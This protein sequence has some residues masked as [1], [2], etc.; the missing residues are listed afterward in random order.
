[1]ALVSLEV[2]LYVVASSAVEET[3][4]ALGQSGLVMKRTGRNRLG[5]LSCWVVDVPLVE[6]E[7]EGRVE[8]SEV[9]RVW[10]FERRFDFSILAQRPVFVWSF[11]QVLH[12]HCLSE[13]M[14]KNNFSSST[15]IFAFNIQ[16]RSSS[17]SSGPPGPPRTLRKSFGCH[18]IPCSC[19]FAVSSRWRSSI[20][21]FS[22]VAAAWFDS[23]M[24]KTVLY[25][26]F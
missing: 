15:Y 23:L 16:S 5:R 8:L 20:F 18:S 11:L 7:V 21:V 25:H 9:K 19:R 17:P 24:A 10:C 1:M 13:R 14:R 2:R 6:R 4:F 22:S 3:S 12:R 26:N